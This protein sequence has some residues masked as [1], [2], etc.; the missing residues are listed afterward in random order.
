[1]SRT[2]KDSPKGKAFHDHQNRQRRRHISVRAVRREPADL[3]RLSRT[4]IAL[5]AAQA[6]V[7]AEAAAKQGAGHPAES[8]EESPDGR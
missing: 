6:E 5:A 2:Y 7:E 4:L 3:R 1:M 8:A